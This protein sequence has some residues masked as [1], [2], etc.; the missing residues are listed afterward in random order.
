VEG[1]NHVYFIKN[2]TVAKAYILNAENY[3][4]AK[5]LRKYE[6][7]EPLLKEINEKIPGKMIILFGSYAKFNPKQDS[8]IDVYIYNLD[9]KAKKDL[10]RLHETLSIKTGD[11]NKEDLLMQEII[12]NHVIIQGGEQYYEKLKLFR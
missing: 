4:L 5:L 8:D 12:R 2:N 10:S 7:L 1:K 3:K 6:T 11:F 9:D